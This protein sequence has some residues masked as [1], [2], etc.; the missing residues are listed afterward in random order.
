MQRIEG[1]KIVKEH[2]KIQDNLIR[3]KVLGLFIGNS[4]LLVAFFMSMQSDNFGSFRNVLNIIAIILCVGIF[5]SLCF[6]IFA[7]SKSI[8]GLKKMEENGVLAYLSGIKS[9]PITD[10][11]GRGRAKRWLTIRDC[12]WPDWFWP[13]V[14]LL[15]M[16][17]WI[18]ACLEN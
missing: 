12:F 14:G 4:V 8:K 11:E 15:F 13:L 9:R 6:D 1:Y 16:L 17:I 10:I 2:L 3:Q 5:L 7:K 18:W